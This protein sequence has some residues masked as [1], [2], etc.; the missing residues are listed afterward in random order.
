MTASPHTPAPGPPLEPFVPVEPDADWQTVRTR[1][2][3]ALARSVPVAWSDHNASDPGVTLVEAVALAVADL[4]YRT[5]DRGLGAWPLEARGWDPDPDRH[6][7]AT[8]PAG[9]QAALADALATPGASAAELEPLVRACASEVEAAALLAAAPW[10]AV[11][12]PDL[13]AA[14]I[15]LLRARLVRQVAHERADVVAAAVD[16]Q[17]A[18]SAAEHAARAVDVLCGVLP[19]WRS[20]VAALVRRDLRRRTHEALALRLDQIRAVDEA[21]VPAL[22]AAL[23]ADGLSAAESGVALAAAPTAA[24]LRPEDLEDVGGHSLLWPPHPVQAL[25]CEPVTGADYARRARAHP[26]VGRAWAVPGRLAGVAWN[27]LATGTDPSIAVDPDAPALTL[28]VERVAGRGAAEPF[29]REV[30]TAA[31]GPEAGLD[32]FPDWRADLD[33][34]APRRL[35]CDEV[36]ASLL[37]VQPVLVQG[38]LVTDIGVD[39]GTLVDGVRARIAAFFQ[40]GRAE[41]DPAADSG[42]DPG[43]AGAELSAEPG[44]VDGPWPRH[45]QPPGGWTPGEPIR[46][47]EVV[48]AIMAQPAVIGVLGLA[49]RLPDE[50]EWVGNPP[51]VLR[52][53]ANAVPTLAGPRCLRVRVHGGATAGGR[54]GCGTGGGAG[55]GHA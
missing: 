5:A 36:G 40:Q 43:H 46:F 18:G 6:W 53:P 11:Y 34:V 39:P 38:D 28:V 49:L 27:G 55:C 2:L 51:G 14:A 19:L 4:H 42:L 13:R 54:A 12:P 47:T 17:R 25:T 21:G 32:P 37:A 52:I 31:I 48:G 15:A 8:L 26:Q 44:V 29:L 22:R 50:A 23:A 45:D 16:A 1:L 35:I 10:S 9:R 41:A 7:H 24:G 33:D 20:E 3:A 30:L